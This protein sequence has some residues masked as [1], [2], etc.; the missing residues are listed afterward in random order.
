MMIEALRTPEHRF[1]VLPNFP[2]RPNYVEDLPSFEGLRM[3]YVDEAAGDEKDTYLCLHGEATWSYL[4]RKMIPV[5]RAAGGRVVAPDFFGFGRSDKPVHDADITYGFHRTALVELIEKLD[6]DNIT[7]VCQDWGGILG[8][9]L[10]M[11]MP[12]RFR[13]LI[14]MNTALPIGASIG[15]GFAAWKAFTAQFNDIPVS[16]VVGSMCSGVVDLMD[17]AAYAAPFPDERYQAGVRR[18]PQLVP[19][20][21]GMEGVEFSKKARTYWS[22]EWNGQSFMAIGMQ[23]GVLGKPVME[24]LRSVIKNCPPALEIGTA[25][26]FVQEWGEQ[27]ANAALAAFDA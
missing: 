18:F 9:T 23:D 12:N 7:L 10:P 14:V 19:V 21:P 27:V 26:H 2:Y 4:Y 13:R 20:E 22:S 11:Q 8:M 1:A 6:L 16:G 15:E 5:F 25:D 24:E 17:L 3:H